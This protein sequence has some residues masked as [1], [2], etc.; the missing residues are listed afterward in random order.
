[1]DCPTTGIPPG[2]DA[3]YVAEIRGRIVAGIGLEVYGRAALL[4]S[5]VVAPLARGKGTGGVLVH[6]VLDHA[7]ERGVSEVFLLTTTA[8]RYFP[9]FGFVPIRRDDV[10]EPIRMSVEFREACPASAIAMRKALLP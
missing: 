10:P 4:R 3:F 1:M 2:L 7:R 5:A 8:E 9:K 6:R